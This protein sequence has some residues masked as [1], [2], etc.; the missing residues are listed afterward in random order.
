MEWKMELA[1]SSPA[2]R[3]STIF[4][5]S[6]VLCLLGRVKEQTLK[7]LARRLGLKRLLRPLL[8]VGG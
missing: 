5:S 4:P 2:Y 1:T 8:R 6:N 7:P 3:S